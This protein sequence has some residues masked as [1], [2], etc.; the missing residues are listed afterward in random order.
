M[1]KD[2]GLPDHRLVH[3]FLEESARRRPGAIALVHGKNRISYLRLNIMANRLACWLLENGMIPGDRA[4]FIFENSPLY[5]VCYYGILKAGGVAVPLSTDLTPRRLTSILDELKPFCVCVS[6]RY[7]RLI[8]EA[9]TSQCG[10]PYLLVSSPKSDRKGRSEA[11]YAVKKLEDIVATGEVSDQS[12]SPDPDSLA[13]ITYTS[14]STGE[15]KGVMLTH[16]NIVANTHSI[17]R[18][19]QLTDRDIQMV[20]LPFFYVMGKSLLNT[21]FA[22]GGRVVI[23]NN[24]AFTAAMIKQMV[25]EKVT[26]FSGVPSTYAYLLCRSPLVHYRSM[27]THLRYCSQAGGHMAAQIK[28][29]LRKAL[30]RHTAIIVMYG[31]TEASARLTWLDPSRFEEKTESIGVEIPGVTIK[32]MDQDGKELPAGETGELVASGDNIMKGY[33]K[34]PEL[35]AKVLDGDGFHTGDMGYRDAEGFIYLTGRKDNQYKVGGH[36]INVQEIEDILLGTRKLIEVAVLGLEDPLLGH[37]LIALGVA[38]ENGLSGEKILGGC[39]KMLPRFKMPRFLY[40]IHSLPKTAS[41]KVD[42]H[43]CMEYIR[44]QENGPG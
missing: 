1:K 7:Q 10:F 28:I 9:D 14:G 16:A 42:R 41:G 36:R 18:F 35:T 20:V 33:W 43:R 30:P 15:S 31:A 22:V 38:R 24:F 34:D 27:L 17:C 39:A 6:G 13:C 32:I 12:L 2:N 11:A 21:H 4:A 37:R 8:D 44:M 29:E 40:L 19:L 25:E 26:G 23:N 5:V 3:H